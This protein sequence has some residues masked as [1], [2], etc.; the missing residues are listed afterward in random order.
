VYRRLIGLLFL[1]AAATSAHGGELLGT[2]DE[3]IGRLDQELDV[4]Y[5]RIAAR[6][7]E[8]TPALAQ[9]RWAPWLPADWNQPRNQLSAQGLAQLR[10][11]LSRELAP[12]ALGRAP[13]AEHAGAALARIAAPENPRLGWWQRVKRWLRGL[14]EPHHEEDADAATGWLGGLD[15]E[16]GAGQVVAGIALVLVIALAAAILLNELRVAGLL[17]RRRVGRGD[18]LTGR[19]AGED[20]VADLE[21]AEPLEQPALLLELITARLTEQERLPPA[22][23]LTTHE[24][25]RRAHLPAE[26]ERPHLAELAAACEYLRFS[27]RTLAAASLAS[28]VSA[29][30]RVLAGLEPKGVRAHQVPERHA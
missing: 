22:R 18:T 26:S 2:L 5:E 30:R 10:T 13:R 3:C 12:R 24:V 19:A 28:A 14:I 15:L 1:L 6:C 23:A 11:L 7:P 8:L 16:H 4:G 25:V 20:A 27:A 17:R 21:A 9:S 29:G